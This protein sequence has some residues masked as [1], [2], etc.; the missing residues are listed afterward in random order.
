MRRWWLV[1]PSIWGRSQVTTW[2]KI[3]EK[4]KITRLF[5]AMLLPIWKRQRSVSWWIIWNIWYGHCF[6]YFLEISDIF[7]QI[8]GETFDF[9]FGDLTDT[10][11]DPGQS[12]TSKDL[13]NFLKYILTLGMQLLVPESGKYFTH[14]NGKSVSNMISKYEETLKDLRVDADLSLRPKFK[15]RECYVPSF[16]ETWI[17]Y[18]ISMCSQ[19]HW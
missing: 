18:Q 12:E 3:K 2:T 7:T 17:F 4:D 9:I 5:V 11:V 6:T 8:R 15:Q 10:P 13:W 14:F 19:W 16:L 1:A